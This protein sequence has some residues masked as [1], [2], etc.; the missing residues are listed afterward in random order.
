MKH[1]QTHPIGL[2]NVCPSELLVCLL[3]DE[4]AELAEKN[5][6]NVFNFLSYDNENIYTRS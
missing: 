3:F 6:R 5:V 4:N 2:C 1:I